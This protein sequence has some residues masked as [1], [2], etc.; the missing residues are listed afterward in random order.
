MLSPVRVFP[1]STQNS[2]GRRKKVPSP[3]NS[4]S[5]KS[6]SC[7]PENAFSGVIILNLDPSAR[8]TRRRGREVPLPSVP[9]SSSFIFVH[10]AQS[11][12][13]SEGDAPARP[14]SV[15]SGVPRRS[16]VSRSGRTGSLVPQS[17]LVA[18]QSTK[19]GAPMRAVL[20]RNVV[21]YSTSLSP[22]PET[23]KNCKTGPSRSS[24]SSHSSVSTV[25]HPLRSI[26]HS[27]HYSRRTF[28]VRGPTSLRTSAFARK[29]SSVPLCGRATSHSGSL[30][31]V[32]VH[33]SSPSAPPS[34]SSAWP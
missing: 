15:W 21:I 25:L 12:T 23:S 18:E 31:R 11:R 19:S 6:T 26:P 22:V 13:W 16:S 30:Q 32:S 17:T 7:S 28:R 34:D 14:E 1:V 29:V 5:V 20:A 10:H 24:T 3:I 4:A 27:A 8:R 33:S 2:P 9:T